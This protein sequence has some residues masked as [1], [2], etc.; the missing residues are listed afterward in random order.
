M[1]TTTQGKG[2]FVRS[3]DMG[4]AIFRL[5]EITD[6]WADDDSVDVLLLEARIV[7]ADEQVAERLQLASDAGGP[8]A[9]LDQPAKGCPSSIRWST[10]PTTSTGL[11]LRRSCR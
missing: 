7:P 10:S 11:W 3:M 4:E 6:V 5:Q 8:L 1:V 2:T 9:P